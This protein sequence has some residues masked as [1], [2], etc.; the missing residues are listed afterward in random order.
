MSSEICIPS[1]LKRDFFTTPHGRKAVNICSSNSGLSNSFPPRWCRG[2]AV[3]DPR[4]RNRKSE[5]F[6]V[7]NSRFLIET[8]GRRH[9]FAP[10]GCG[11][12]Y[13]IGTNLI[14]PTALRSFH[15]IKSGTFYEICCAQRSQKSARGRFYAFTGYK[16]SHS[17]CL[18]LKN[19]SISRLR[20]QLS[21]GESQG[22]VRITK[23]ALNCDLCGWVEIG[24]VSGWRPALGM[25]YLVSK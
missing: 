9:G 4:C 22:L 12:C 19:L 1:F 16:N 3:V 23:R 8:S 20:R 6:A 17:K 2:E 18:F 14:I 7:K 21:Q 5:L 24:Q 13:E 15:F 25:G 10:T 11:A